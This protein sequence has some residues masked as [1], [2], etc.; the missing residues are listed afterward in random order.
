M[1]LIKTILFISLCLSVSFAQTQTIQQQ[2]EESDSNL[3]VLE[4]S[5]NDS[6][7][8]GD[9]FIF[10]LFFPTALAATADLLIMAGV[11]GLVSKKLQEDF[12]LDLD[13]LKTGFDSDPNFNERKSTR[14]LRLIHNNTELAITKSEKSRERLGQFG[15]SA[16]AIAELESLVSLKNQQCRNKENNKSPENFC[17]DYGDNFARDGYE[18]TRAKGGGWEVRKKGK[19]KVLCCLEWDD[20]HCG[21]EIFDKRGRHKGEVG[22]LPDEFN[23]CEYN[24]NRG[25]HAVPSPSNHKP[26]TRACGAN[27]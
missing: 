1:Y 26:R 20:L 10:A 17:P 2:I 23:P 8:N 5:F 13:I 12:D 11:A 9:N 6:N 21:F 7:S 16:R 14:E 27:K 19:R 4:N 3:L 24:P 15:Y 22:C 25:K 18:V